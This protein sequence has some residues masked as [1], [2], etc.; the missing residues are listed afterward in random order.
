MPT[1]LFDL[2]KGVTLDITTSSIPFSVEQACREENAFPV[3]YTLY[4]E[5]GILKD[6]LCHMCRTGVIMDTGKMIS[7][8]KTFKILTTVS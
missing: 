5:G 6:I 8:Y 4:N 7:G 2:G 1:I 3:P